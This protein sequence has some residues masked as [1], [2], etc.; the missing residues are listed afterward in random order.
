MPEYII[1]KGDTLSKIAKNNNISLSELTKL[2]SIKDPNNIQYG[3]KIIIPN[4][5]NKVNYTIKKGDTLNDLAIKHKIKLNDLINLNQ[6]ED[7]NKINYGQKIYIPN[8]QT[9]SIKKETP[10][11]VSN[12]HNITSNNS[13]SKSANPLD[14]TGYFQDI[15]SKIVLPKKEVTKQNLLSENNYTFPNPIQTILKTPIKKEVTKQTQKNQQNRTEEPDVLEDL[16]NLTKGSYL[17]YSQMAKTTFD[18]KIKPIFLG[19]E[20]SKQSISKM[21]FTKPVVVDKPINYDF[22]IG[23]KI[24]DIEFGKDIYHTSKYID[25]SNPEIKTKY[26]NRGDKIKESIPFK[27]ILFS[28]FDNKKFDDVHYLKNNNKLSSNKY[29]IGT[30]Y[31][32]KLIMGTK[33]EVQN[34]N[35]VVSDFA[36]IKNVTGFSKTN[37]NSLKVVKSKYAKNSVDP[38]L[39]T[40]NGEIS[41]NILGGTDN[42][43]NNKY[44]QW[45]GGSIIVTSPD[46]K[47]KVLI[48]GSL[49]EVNQGLEKFKKDNSLNKVNVIKVDNGSFS[50]QFASESNSI[51]QDF[52]D[53][54]EGLNNSGGNAIYQ[55]KDGGKVIANSMDLSN[56]GGDRMMKKMQGGGMAEYNNIN[57][58]TLGEIDYTVDPFTLQPLYS[59][60]NFQSTMQNYNPNYFE[61]RQVNKD[62]KI[63]T[64]PK[65]KNNI[66]DRVD[67]S[68]MFQETSESFKRNFSNMSGGMKK[69]AGGIGATN[70]ADAVLGAVNMVGDVTTGAISA[71]AKP[72]SKGAAY[73]EG[74]Q[75]AQSV[76]KPLEN[77]PIVGQA[78]KLISGVI[79]GALNARKQGIEDEETAKR[80]K[81]LEYLTRNT[82]NVN[83]PSYYGNYM[84]KY[85]A[86]PKMMEQRV[87]DDIYS[88]FDKYLKL[89]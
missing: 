66:T 30:D 59:D 25:L 73:A 39:T 84:A 78:S 68:S 48:S 64:Y 72:G 51:N 17:K 15:K 37:S 10:K 41:I 38:I 58:D 28:N 89:T 88:D 61:N 11:I 53:K 2:N 24:P 42:E 82:M 60:I 49:N 45:Y 8:L 18:R 67:D 79:G 43:G 62:N 40:D 77:I 54:Y 5:S 71:F 81:Q 36:V 57:Y 9:V 47:K 74:S 20:D 63:T 27:Q 29:Y 34:I 85:G 26:H 31:Q 16:Y 56:I 69:F 13:N 76:V 6:I 70:P 46:N 55:Y 50:R 65:I 75:M 87:I 44:G 52:W 23:N 35:G 83:Q 21:D 12:Y 33:D 22:I 19:T 3:N 14:L 7:P 80:D 4:S 86:N 1:K 32:G